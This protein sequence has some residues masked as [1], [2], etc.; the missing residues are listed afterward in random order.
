LRWGA[1]IR[2]AGCPYGRR[3]S[4]FG[5]TVQPRRVARDVEFFVRYGEPLERRLPAPA[6]SGMG[7]AY[8]AGESDTKRRQSRRSGSSAPTN[9][10][11]ARS[12]S[13][14]SAPNVSCAYG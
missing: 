14:I 3:F 5:E 2:V 11:P 6:R 9:V 1:V 8:L 7:G 4:D 13:A 12:I 10:T